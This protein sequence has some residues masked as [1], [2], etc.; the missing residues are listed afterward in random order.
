[1]YKRWR[2]KY[3]RR[4]DDDCTCCDQDGHNG[5]VAV[6]GRNHN[7]VPARVVALMWPTSTIV[8]IDGNKLS[9]AERV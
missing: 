2:K 3:G 8:R 5:R 9:K 6:L 7:S 4:F 1:M